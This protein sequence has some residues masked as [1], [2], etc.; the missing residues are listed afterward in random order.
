MRLRSGGRGGHDGGTVIG[1]GHDQGAPPAGEPFDPGAG[2]EE[3]GRN[4]R[5]VA[6][7]IAKGGVPGDRAA[8]GHRAVSVCFLYTQ[9]GFR[10]LYCQWLHGTFFT[11]RVLKG[12]YMNLTPAQLRAA[13]AMLAWS[14]DELAEAA[15]VHRNTVLRAEKGEATVPTLA[16]LRIAL[17]GAGVLFISAEGGGEGVRLATPSEAVSIIS[18]KRKAEAAS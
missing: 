16:A 5:T 3:A 17:E 11:L 4:L 14:I 15:S 13:R 7:Q 12:A 9:C 8:E 10:L 6:A 2:T 1:T 18:R